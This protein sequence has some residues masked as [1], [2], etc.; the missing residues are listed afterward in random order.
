MTSS[1]KTILTMMFGAI[2]LV[3]GCSK[4]ESEISEPVTIS[5]TETLSGTWGGHE[6]G[7]GKE[8]EPSVMFTETTLEFRGANPQEWY[9]ATYTLQ[10]DTDPKRIDLVVTDCPFPNYVGQ[11]AH[12]IY[13]IED[14][15]LI[16]TGNEP[17]NPDVPMSFDQPGARQFVFTLE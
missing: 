13:K 2:I 11:T 17:G 5:D 8:G 4:P 14:S 10:E 12:G 6:V 16:M 3:S 7:R 1:L 9:E 15:K